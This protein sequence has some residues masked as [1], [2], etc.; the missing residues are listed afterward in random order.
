[1]KKGRKTEQTGERVNTDSV[2]PKAAPIRNNNS[3]FS[4]GLLLTLNY[5]NDNF[6]KRYI[7]KLTKRN[8]FTD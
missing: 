6:A 8:V 4:I 5:I 2:P 3:L 1:M 7:E